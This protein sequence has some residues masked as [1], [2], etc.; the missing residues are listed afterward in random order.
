MVPEDKIPMTYQH[1]L[2]AIHAHN[3]H[4]GTGFISTNYLLQLL[5]NR[6]ESVLA[7]KMI[8]Q[9][10]YPG[11]KTLTKGGVFQEDWYGNEAQMPSCGGAV[12]AWLFQS[13]LGIQ[14][15]ATQ[16]AFKRFILSP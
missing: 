3:D 13:V 1:L 6:R 5:A 16:P 8:H 14:P 9:Q 10:D 7:N 12:G 2:D 11:W 4:V 15:D